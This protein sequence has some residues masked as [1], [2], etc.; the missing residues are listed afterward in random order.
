MNLMHLDALEWDETPISSVFHRE[1]LELLGIH[2]CTLAVSHVATGL[3]LWVI[4]LL[5]HM[6]QEQNRALDTQAVFC[7]PWFLG[8]E[9]CPTPYK[10]MF[11]TDLK[12]TAVSPPDLRR[13]YK[14][15][16]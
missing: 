7:W 4:L 14:V 9:A 16:G 10:I 2:R 3:R 13:S 12:V 15:Q 1:L 5:S 11:L 8:S 6:N